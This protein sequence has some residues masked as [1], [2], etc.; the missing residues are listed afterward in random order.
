MLWFFKTSKDIC[1]SI[2]HI[3][4]KD[5]LHTRR[6]KST[7]RLPFQSNVIKHKCLKSRELH[8]TTRS[9]TYSA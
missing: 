8:S 1:K 5:F 4:K 2:L 3:N 6:N 7:L 9:K